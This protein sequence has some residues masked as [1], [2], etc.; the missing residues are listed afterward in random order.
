MFSMFLDVCKNLMDYIRK[1]WISSG[2]GGDRNSRGNTPNIFSR[3][4]FTDQFAWFGTFCNGG[5]MHMR[6]PSVIFI[7]RRMD[8]NSDHLSNLEGVC[9]FIPTLILR[10]C[11]HNLQVGRKCNSNLPDILEIDQERSV[12]V[13]NDIRPAH[14]AVTPTKLLPFTTIMIILT[15]WAQS[16]GGRYSPTAPSQASANGLFVLQTDGVLGFVLCNQFQNFGHIDTVLQHW[17]RSQ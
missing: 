7:F 9:N 11:V 6:Q 1:L 4:K 8:R 14:I 12:L 3:F 13:K 16:R 17:I 10:L 2:M 15:I 5:V